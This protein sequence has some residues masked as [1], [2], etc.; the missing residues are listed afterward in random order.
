MSETFCNDADLHGDFGFTES[1]VNTSELIDQTANID[2][3]VCN[4]MG[5]SIPTIF[6]RMFLFSSAYK[7][8]N[9]LETV[10]DASNAHIYTTD[11]K[12]GAKYQNVYHYLIS[13]HLDMLEFLFT[14]SDDITVEKW[15]FK[16]EK[17]FLLN[18]QNDYPGL[19][20]L[21]KA[22][23]SEILQT[24]SLNKDLG[25]QVLLFKYKGELVGGTSPDFIVFTNP[26]WKEI[27]QNNDWNHVFNPLFT[28]T[29]RPLHVRPL[30]FRKLLTMLAYSG[31]LSNV[32]DFET[33]IKDSEHNYD[34]VVRNWWHN[35]RA[36]HAGIVVPSWIDS[37]ISKVANIMT[38]TC[39]GNQS[40]VISPIQGIT[41]Y[42]Q[43]PHL[44]FETEYKI[45]PTTDK[46]NKETIHGGEVTL[47]GEPMLIVENGIPGAKYF[48]STT[49]S[50]TYN[51]P[52][53]SQLK[54]QYLSQRA[55]PGM[56]GTMYPIITV[57]DLLE[58]NIVELAYIV[59]KKHFFTGCNANLNF[60]LP[61]KHLYF[62]FFTFEDLKRNLTVDV[63]RNADNEILSVNVS[64]VIPM[65][66]PSV[67]SYCIK[68]SYSYSKDARFKIVDCRK[69]NNAFNMGIFPF[70]RSANNNLNN[71]RFMLGETTTKVEC[72]VGV[73]DKIGFI[74]PRDGKEG[75]SLDFI[76]RSKREAL[77]TSFA[78]YK[79]IFDYIDLTV[80]TG[81]QKVSGMFFP[82]MTE[83]SNKG[84]DFKWFYSV[85]FGTSNTH[86]V[87]ADVGIGIKQDCKPF[88]YH[89]I[90]RQMVT[91][92]VEENNKFLAF[93]N[94][95][96]REFVPSEF[97]RVGDEDL[98]F[99]VRSV[100]YE[101]EH[102]TTNINLFQ[103]RNIGFNYKKEI[104]EN[105]QS[106][107]Y[108]SDIKWNQKNQTMFT[109]R[110]QA[111]CSQILW[112]LRNHSLNNG[113]TEKIRVAVTYPLA[114]S[115]MQLRAIKDAWRNAW[116]D[117]IDKNIKFEDAGNQFTLESV[118]PYKYSVVNN[119]RLNRTDA[120]INV[121]IGG[122][123]TDILYYKE[124]HNGI[125]KSNAYS[126]FFA[127]NDIWGNGLDPLN[128]NNKE[129]GYITALERTLNP[130]QKSH[131]DNYK[132][133]ANTSTDVIN[134][135]FSI[136]CCKQMVWQSN[137]F[138]DMIK[139]FEVGSV[140][141]VHFSALM[142]YLAHIIKMD[143]LETPKVINF[144]GMGS[145]YI[146]IISSDNHE[147]EDL[148]KAIFRYVG[149]T[150]ADNVTVNMERDP[151][152]VTAIG[153]LY[154]LDER[155]TPI[156]LP[157]SKNVYC[158]K[159]EEDMDEAPTYLYAET[160]ECRQKTLEQAM[161]FLKL[162]ND[163]QFRNVVRNTG[164][165]YSFEKLQDNGLSRNTLE[166][167][168]IS[169]TDRFKNIPENDK[170]EKLK[171]APFFWTLKETLY[172][173]ANQ[174]RQ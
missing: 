105:F 51:V 168:Y 36:S 57:D 88:S 152:E 10:P 104:S 73:F 45:A 163:G 23:E 126:V 174:L 26:N 77:T 110:V 130:T 155:T 97:G 64:L 111:Y 151:K 103:E 146:N 153:A 120:Y 28:D 33:Y 75:D 58:E 133:L 124:N 162:L 63:S 94:D 7:D 2:Y 160:D 113:G 61:I 8:I 32:L 92:G 12:S 66:T 131:L 44:A 50:N 55:V 159:D 122:G 5:S 142:Y 65:L 21:A 30:P 86:I 156:S 54:N 121:D 118:A 140:L 19:G 171:D 157:A 166:S 144:T 87:M 35:V 48:N 40:D 137:H 127:A 60:M 83:I 17:Q 96:A 108:V 14:Y 135:L 93:T 29:A 145:K 169:M 154:M 82:L 53:Y 138:P 9:L 79:G 136:Q 98:K 69:G 90:S 11:P 39:N 67:G 84:T 112:M 172:K 164:I 114:M 102:A 107:S 4:K 143:R 41:I 106:N 6:A 109:C 125:N 24:P 74:V 31:K 47:V 13:E 117:Y 101:K 170:K 22:I 139:Q 70:F 34:N 20:R 158:I 167:S 99:P 62:R 72:R 27:I 81:S 123:S 148:I 78:E 52:V 173:I 132:K 18:G 100:I 49:W 150:D 80:N 16:N 37:E 56:V 46:W 59:D 141:V 38:W 129:N 95:I 89:G 119:D 115:P 85:D 161:D 128:E 3:H 116:E 1:D 149:L 147:I 134:Y 71:Y 76:Q 25:M 68:R 15:C 43:S 42:C 91:F 165:N